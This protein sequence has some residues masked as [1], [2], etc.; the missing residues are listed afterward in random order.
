MGYFLKN[1]IKSFVLCFIFVCGV[2]FLYAQDQDKQSL[3]EALVSSGQP[4]S[5]TDD[6]FSK[7]AY[8]SKT[9]AE[10]NSHYCKQDSDCIGSDSCI[11][12][13]QCVSR[14]DVSSMQVDCYGIC[15]KPVPHA[16]MCED[17]RCVAA[18]ER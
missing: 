12:C 16:C 9:A 10:A 15:R 14:A 8:A 7:A 2:V 18:H 5:A 6:N 17:N 4:S 13:G 11:F 1:N 3:A